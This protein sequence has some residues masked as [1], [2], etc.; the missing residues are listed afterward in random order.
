MPVPLVYERV[1]HVSKID[2]SRSIGFTENSRHSAEKLVFCNDRRN[3]IHVHSEKPKSV[4]T[5]FTTVVELNLSRR[6]GCIGTPINQTLYWN[7]LWY[8]S[9]SLRNSKWNYLPAV[10]TCRSCILGCSQN[11]RLLVIKPALK[12]YCGFYSGWFQLALNNIEAYVKSFYLLL[13][14]M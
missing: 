9:V 13:K 2:E 7:N 1:L 10:A 6:R 5:M 11:I 8:L 12:F 14:E 4:N 3:N